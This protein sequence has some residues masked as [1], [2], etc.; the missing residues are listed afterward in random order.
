[1]D[2][3]P[4][5]PCPVCLQE[6]PA[7]ATYFRVDRRYADGLYHMCKT[8]DNA[9]DKQCPACLNWY[10]RSIV[11]F[12]RDKGRKDGLCHHCKECS[13]K[14]TK[15]HYKEHPEYYQEYTKTHVE[16][17]NQH[18]RNYHRT[19]V[20]EILLLNRNREIRRKGAQ[21]TYTA[22]D[23]QKQ[24]ANQK[25]KCYYCHIK[26]GRDYHVDHVI[27][28]SRGGSN[29][30]SNLVLACPHC[31]LSKNSKLPHEWYEGGRLL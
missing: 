18:T 10:P 14:K 3:I 1:M 19:H 4:S 23:I 7:T 16:Q 25:G 11:Y 12:N 22:Q 6:F 27:P 17:I 26:M 8:C 30:P 31:N 2:S 20:K 5:K 28:L 9:G 13:K 29:D 15:K 24:Y 21:G